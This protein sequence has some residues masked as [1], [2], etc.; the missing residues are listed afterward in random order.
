MW[1]EATGVEDIK[2]NGM[3]AVILTTFDLE[4]LVYRKDDLYFASFARCPHGD[5]MLSGGTFD[6]TIVRC[7]GHDYGF[8]V[9]SG[10]CDAHPSYS[11]I[12]LPTKVEN[13]KVFIK[14]SIRDL[15]L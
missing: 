3:K 14:I 13:E 2:P 12:T 5:V 4:V 10:Q 9:E 6:G 15:I 11:L 1:F 8:N 7:S